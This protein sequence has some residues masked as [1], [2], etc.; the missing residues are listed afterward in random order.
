MENTFWNNSR[1]DNFVELFKKSFTLY[2]ES[3]MRKKTEA[4]IDELRYEQGRHP[5]TEDFKA[6]FH[7]FIIDHYLHKIY[8]YFHSTYLTTIFA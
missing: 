3:G 6:K 5:V 2:V 1:D 7:N 4:E 8:F